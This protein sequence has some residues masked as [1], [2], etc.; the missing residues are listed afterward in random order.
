M[1]IISIFIERICVHVILDWYGRN[2]KERQRLDNSYIVN[3]NILNGWKHI[4]NITTCNFVITPTKK[5]K[6]KVMRTHL[7]GFLNYEK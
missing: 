1:L 7:F 6:S 5:K 4:Y 2:D 3:D